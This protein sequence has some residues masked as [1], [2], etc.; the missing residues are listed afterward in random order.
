MPKTTKKL[1]KKQ[2]PKKFLISIEDKVKEAIKKFR[3]FTKKD[4]ILVAVSGGKDSTLALYILKKLGYNIEALAVDSDIGNYTKQNIEN[5][6]KICDDLDV[7]LNIIS[8]RGE[9]GHSLCYLR[10][11]INS[12]GHKLNSCTICGVLRRYLINKYAKKLKAD[13]LVTGHNLD[14]ECQAILMNIF[15][16]NIF[17]LSRL[18]PISGLKDSE[19]FVQRVKPLYFVTEK[20]A[21]RYTKIKKFP[22]KYGECPC[23]TTS[24]RHTIKEKLWEYELKNKDFKK[25]LL[26]KFLKDL[27]KLK[28]RF[29]TTKEINSCS[30]CNEPSKGKICMACKLMGL[31]SKDKAKK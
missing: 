3:L 5:L 17:F 8:F 25:N 13:I 27:P 24:Y 7:K 4:S 6:K 28:Q 22:V 21:E 20:E 19:K 26:K 23:S 16:N 30:E 29:K 12:K 1:K 2:N 10:S 14:D 11:L 31:I 15:K 18:G 9:F